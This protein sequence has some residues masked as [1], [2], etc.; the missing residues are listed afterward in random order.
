[1][2]L[3]SASPVGGNLPFELKAGD[4]DIGRSKE[5]DIIILDSSVSPIHARLRVSPAGKLHLADLG[6]KN[7]SSD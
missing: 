4:F 1:M 3:I 5:C 6:S 2:W 7:G